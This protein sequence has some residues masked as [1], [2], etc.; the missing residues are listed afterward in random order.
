MFFKRLCFKTLTQQSLTKAHCY[1]MKKIVLSPTTS[2]PVGL[3]GY[4]N[5]GRAASQVWRAMGDRGF[6]V[7]DVLGSNPRG[8]PFLKVSVS[9]EIG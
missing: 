3:Y 7:R 5:A 9:N 8:T 1:N 4:G 6:G 2:S